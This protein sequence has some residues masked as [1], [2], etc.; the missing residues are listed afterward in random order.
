MN[1]LCLLEWDVHLL[2]PLD[3]AL[4]VLGPLHLG[5]NYSTGF[6]RSLDCGQQIMGLLGPH[7]NLLISIDLSILLVPL[8]WRTLI[9]VPC[10]FQVLE[11]GRQGSN[12][13][14]TRAR[15]MRTPDAHWESLQT[16]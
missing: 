3:M 6:P 7:I 12:P 4:L 11:R 2:L 14:R 8:L 16:G 10:K 15:A 13:Q 1:S 5:L 9:H